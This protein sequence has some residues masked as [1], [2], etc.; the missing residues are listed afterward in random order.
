VKESAFI[1]MILKLA[2]LRGWRTAHFRPGMNRRGKWQTAVQGDGAGF[3]D[4]LLLRGAQI[5][6]AELKVGKNKTTPEQVA[7]LM[8]FGSAGVP[9]FTW[10]PADWD[11]IELVLEKGP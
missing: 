3:P 5:I 4:L 6:V 9:A 1:A 8:A 2:R 7:W 11:E 10:T